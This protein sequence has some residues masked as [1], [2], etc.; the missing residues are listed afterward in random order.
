MQ[1]R[2]S[3]AGC[4]SPRLAVARDISTAAPV[5]SGL[6]ANW[7][8]CQAQP[9]CGPSAASLQLAPL[10]VETS[11][12]ATPPSAQAQPQISSACGPTRASGAGATITD[13]GAIS[14]TGRVPPSTASL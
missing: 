6:Q 2:Q 1:L 10:S 3:A 12:L 7:N 8:F 4:T 13:S 11:T 9:R 5:P 14:H